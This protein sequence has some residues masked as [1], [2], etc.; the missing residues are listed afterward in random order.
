M[1]LDYRRIKRHDKC[2]CRINDWSLNEKKQCH[3]GH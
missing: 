3:K 1:F 2:K